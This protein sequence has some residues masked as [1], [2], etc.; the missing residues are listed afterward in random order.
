M[1]DF[2]RVAAVVPD[3]FVGDVVKNT[4]AILAKAQQAK[5]RI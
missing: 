3:V 4:D 2:V 1:L 5:V